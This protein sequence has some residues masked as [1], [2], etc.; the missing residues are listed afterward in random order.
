MSRVESEALRMTHLVEDLLLLA[1][2]DSGRPLERR[3][4]DL[5]RLSCRRRQRRPRRRSRTSLESRLPPDPLYVAG[6]DA[7]LHQVVANLLA[8]ARV[9]T[10]PGTSVTLSLDAEPDAAVLR[11]TRRRS[12]AS[13]PACSPRSSNV[14]PAA[15]PRAPARAAPPGW[16]WRSRRRSSVPTAAVSE[17]KAC[18]ATPSSS[19]GCRAPTARTPTDHI[20]PESISARNTHSVVI[21]RTNARPN[22]VPDGGEHDH[23]RCPCGASTKT[24]H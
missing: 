7:R 19:C 4:V 18:P 20:E 2:L 10:P 22:P 13:R 15:T 23:H 11:V 5:A 8:N 17:C 6:D 21:A 12:R 3:P 14:S 9:H 1:R 16:V 24:S